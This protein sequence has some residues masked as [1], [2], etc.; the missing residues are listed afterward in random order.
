MDVAGAYGG[1][2]AGATFNPI[3]FLQ[4]P[5]VLLRALCWVCILFKKVKIFFFFFPKLLY[6]HTCN[7]GNYG[8][9]YLYLSNIIIYYLIHYI[10]RYICTYIYISNYIDMKIENNRY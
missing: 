1:G 6:T 2:K 5:Q 7:F 10:Y 4:R 8:G 9:C 3:Q